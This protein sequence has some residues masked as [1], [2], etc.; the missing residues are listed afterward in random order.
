MGNEDTYSNQVKRPNLY[1]H[2]CVG[3]H[4]ESKDKIDKFF[5]DKYFML[6]VLTKSYNTTNYNQKEKIQSI[7]RDYQIRLQTNKTLYAEVG[8]TTERLET[9]DEFYSLGILSDYTE[10]YTFPQDL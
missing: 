1:I 2:K 10:F 6:T 3:S 5:N 7:A 8:I 9:D 4:C